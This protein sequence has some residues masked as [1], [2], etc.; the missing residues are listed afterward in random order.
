[1][2]GEVAGKGPWRLFNNKEDN[3]KGHQRYYTFIASM[4]VSLDEYVSRF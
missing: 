3:N 4:G 2:I 1:V